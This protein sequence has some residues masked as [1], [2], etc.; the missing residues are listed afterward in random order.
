MKSTVVL[1]N[2]HCCSVIEQQ[3]L[4]DQTLHLFNQSMIFLRGANRDYCYGKCV[5]PSV[6]LCV[7]QT[8]GLPLTPRRVGQK[9]KVSDLRRKL[10]FC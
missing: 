3:L 7:C 4:S 9:R 5:S 1:P 2:V 8:R 10:N 6:C